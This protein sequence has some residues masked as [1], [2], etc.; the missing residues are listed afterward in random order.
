MISLFQRRDALK[1]TLVAKLSGT[2]R[3]AELNFELLQQ[4]RGSGGAV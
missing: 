4:Q 2:V 3:S 1:N